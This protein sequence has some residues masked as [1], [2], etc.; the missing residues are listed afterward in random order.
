MK[1]A[2]KYYDQ[3]KLIKWGGRRRILVFN[4]SIID[5]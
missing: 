3:S 1:S 4:L 5:I 2:C